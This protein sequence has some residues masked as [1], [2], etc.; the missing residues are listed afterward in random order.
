MEGADHSFRG[1][2]WPEGELYP[3]LA[4]RTVQWIEAL[5]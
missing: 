2:S 5:D 3:F 1:K 4:D